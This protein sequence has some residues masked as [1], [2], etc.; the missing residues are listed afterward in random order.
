MK[1]FFIFFIAIFF[2]KNANADSIDGVNLICYSKVA[3]EGE[4]I[5]PDIEYTKEAIYLTINFTKDEAKY[6]FLD[7]G[8]VKEYWGQ[9][10]LQPTSVVIKQGGIGKDIGRIDRKTLRLTILKDGQYMLKL[11]GL[12]SNPSKALTFCDLKNDFS[13]EQNINFLKNEW[14]KRLKKLQEGNKF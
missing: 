13:H 8:G 12:Y 2:F 7:Y 1:K 14:E 4:I 5:Y 9:Y 6:G 10:D 3:K 11:Y